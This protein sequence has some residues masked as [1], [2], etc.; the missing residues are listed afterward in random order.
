MDWRIISLLVLVSLVGAV[1]NDILTDTEEFMDDEEE[2]LSVRIARET[3]EDEFYPEDERKKRQ[4]SRYNYQR[5]LEN[6]GRA[7]Y[8][9][10]AE[11]GWP[12]FTSFAQPVHLLLHMHSEPALAE[13]GLLLYHTN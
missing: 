11:E 7:D 1:T 8:D 3:A 13:M 5:Y 12:Q 2:P 9:M 6:I 10:R 4:I